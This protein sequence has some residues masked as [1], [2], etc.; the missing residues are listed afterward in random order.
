[1]NKA[2]KLFGHALVRMHHLSEPL[3]DVLVGRSTAHL[4]QPLQ[5]HYFQC[6]RR[7]TFWRWVWCL[8]LD[9]GH[10]WKHWQYNSAAPHGASCCPSR[11]RR[12]LHAKYSEDMCVW[13]AALAV[14]WSSMLWEWPDW[15][16]LFY[17]DHLSV[18]RAMSGRSGTRA[19]AQ[20]ISQDTGPVRFN[21]S[22]PRHVYMEAASNQR[23]VSRNQHCGCRVFDRRQ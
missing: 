20:E 12:R 1:M 3:C 15:Q 23:Q 22:E 11:H 18:L 21:I 9:M 14:G 5:A 19:A 17:A 6:T 16:R 4:R 7:H 10:P 8:P 13:A 2:S